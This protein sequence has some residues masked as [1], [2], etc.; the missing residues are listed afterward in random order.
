[1]A[2]NVTPATPG[3][4][5]SSGPSDWRGVRYA[6]TP[7]GVHSVAAWRVKL[8]AVYPTGAAAQ[9]AALEGALRAARVAL[10]ADGRGVGFVIAHRG[11]DRFCFVTGWWPRPDALATALHQARPH[12]PTVPEPMPAQY[13]SCVWELPVIA[14]ER[15]AWMDAYTR[16]AGRPDVEGYLGQFISG[17]L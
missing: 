12:R 2:Q 15:D 6:V 1:M 17:L 11:P 8:H 16:R 5:P 13:V 3:E 10:P 4:P 9:P 14:H 7:L